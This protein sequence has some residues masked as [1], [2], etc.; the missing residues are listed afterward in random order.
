V[1]GLHAPVEADRWSD[2]P[3]RPLR[4]FQSVGGICVDEVRDSIKCCRER[5]RCIHCERR[6]TISYPPMLDWERLGVDAH[7]RT[8]TTSFLVLV[9]QSGSERNSSRTVRRSDVISLE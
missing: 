3:S 9:R 5:T 1:P 8:Y 7:W 2:W 6:W 4:V